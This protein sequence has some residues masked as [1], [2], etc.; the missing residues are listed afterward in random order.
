MSLNLQSR[1][2]VLGIAACLMAAV[3]VA[4]Q[5]RPGEVLRVA[6]GFDKQAFSYRIELES[7]HDSFRV[8]RLTYPSPVPSPVAQNNTIPAELYLPKG[9]R[10]GSPP[11]PAVIC[12]HILGGG[13]ELA[14][15]QCTALAA[16]GIPAI[17]FKLPYYAERGIPGGTRALAADPRLFAK[18]L[19]QGV[20]DV[21]RTFDVLASQ[22]EVNPRQIGVMGV[23]MGGILA[24]TAAGQ[25]PRI[26]RA[27]LLLAGGDLLPIVHHAR[28]TR[29]LSETINRLPPAERA[30]IERAIV[31]ADPLQ[32]AAGLRERA[33]QG[34]VL[35]INAGR[36]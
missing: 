9:I 3:A 18:A 30:E 33:Q 23:S 32:Y 20:E 21:R 25:E 15:L 24:G 10:P 16:R 27:V 36:R 1:R 4:A 26:A 5:D 28:E 7:E 13:F 35:M 29:A 19:A 17:W 31:R 12:L 34:R 8:Y 14:R 11:R 22:P 2:I 6:S